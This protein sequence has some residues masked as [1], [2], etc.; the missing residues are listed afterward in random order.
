MKRISA[1]II[2]FI[3]LLSPA[4]AA[5]ENTGPIEVS[6]DNIEGFILESSP[7]LKIIKNEL[8]ELES[9]YREIIGDLNDLEDQMDAVDL[10]TPNGWQTAVNLTSQ[11]EAL[12]NQRDKAKYNLDIAKMKYDQQVSE[13][14]LSAS[15]IFINC[16]SLEVQIKTTENN[17]AIQQKSL[18]SSYDKLT[19]GFISQKQYEGL[20]DQLKNIEDNLSNLKGQK[21]VAI[22][23]LAAA[24]GFTESTE[25]TLKNIETDFVFINDIDFASD[26]DIMFVNNIEISAKEYELKYEENRREKNRIAIDNARITLDQTKEKALSDFTEAYNNLINIYRSLLSTEKDFKD[27]QEKYFISN[28]L[29]EKGCISKKQLEDA[30]L[31][32]KNLDLQLSYDKMSLYYSYLNYQN[33]K[34][35]Y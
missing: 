30:E 5:A 31:E 3:F 6:L 20:S 28:L 32:I 26:T 27:K 19:K 25:L 14:F 22:L 10:S 34:D 18:S 13:L 4:A 7:D 9:D 21:D 8:S 23:R 33:L 17:L 11:M 15:Q 35:G 24:L 16:Y 29:Y 1:C 12:R 2:V